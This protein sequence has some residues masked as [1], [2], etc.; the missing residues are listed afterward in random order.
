MR[1]VK[2]SFL[3]LVF[4]LF[5][6]GPAR[7][8]T[9]ACTEI[10]Q[11]NQLTD[12]EKENFPPFFLKLPLF[13]TINVHFGYGAAIQVLKVTNVTTGE[14]QLKAISN[15]KAPSLDYQT[16][17]YIKKI[18]KIGQKFEL[19]LENGRHIKT[20]ET[21]GQISVEG[22]KFKKGSADDFIKV[23]NAIDEKRGS[24]TKTIETPTGPSALGVK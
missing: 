3:T 6:N 5:F 2:V 21:E 16:D 15:V 24:K 23:S 1:F 11:L 22:H 12:T 13:L 4:V 9:Q 7:S 8:A 17:C 18:C 19:V 14:E 10:K 20:E